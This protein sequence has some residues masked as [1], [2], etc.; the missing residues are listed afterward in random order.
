MK[1]Y[2]FSMTLKFEA[3]DQDDA[4]SAADEIIDYLNGGGWIQVIVHDEHPTE[5]Q[6]Q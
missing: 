2:R 1:K 4:E 6:T 3:E 5:E